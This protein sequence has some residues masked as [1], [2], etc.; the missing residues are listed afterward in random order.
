MALASA[1]AKTIVADDRLAAS[2]S[3]GDIAGLFNRYAKGFSG[4]ASVTPESWREEVREQSW[5]APSL[6][7]DPDCVRLAERDGKVVGYALT[8]YQ[9]Y[10]LRHA[11]LVQELFVDDVEAAEEVAAALIED[12]EKQA[13]ARDKECVMLMLSPEDGRAQRAV[14][15]GDGQVQLFEGVEGLALVYPRAGVVGV[16]PQALVVA[17]D[18]LVVP[19]H[20]VKRLAL[21]APAA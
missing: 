13:R 1:S 19:A 12:A 20:A 2:D 17:R 10:E 4:A 11:A 18:G 6:D 3:L 14:E 15:A 7:A 9:P 8:D 5:N 21:V 16:Q